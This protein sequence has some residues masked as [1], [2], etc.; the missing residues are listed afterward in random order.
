MKLTCSDYEK[1]SVGEFI[2]DKNNEV[3]NISLFNRKKRF[4]E[5]KKYL[6]LEK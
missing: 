6:I 1:F 5:K 3:S 2:I 4:I